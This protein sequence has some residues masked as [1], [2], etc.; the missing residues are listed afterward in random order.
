MM[1]VF[2]ISAFDTVVAD[3]VSVDPIHG[4]PGP[5]FTVPKVTFDTVYDNPN[6]PISGVTCSNGVNG[7]QGFTKLG[8]IPNAPFLGGG[9]VV[10]GGNTTNCGTC[11]AMR[12]PPVGTVIFVLV[13]D[14]C[15]EGFNISEE[16]MQALTNGTG[17]ESGVVEGV[18]ATQVG[19]AAC[20]SF[21]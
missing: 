17:V 2:I 16:A 5:P 20:G 18:V 6:F 13:V 15:A 9:S 10:S 7:L 12:W 1:T 8:D 21:N 4:T 3:D 14:S 19:R 11:F